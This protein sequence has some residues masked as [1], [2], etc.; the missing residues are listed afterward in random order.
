MTVLALAIGVTAGLL[1]RR[2]VPAMAMTLVAVVGLQIALP[3][4]VQAHLVEPDAMTTKI[5]ADNFA[6]LRGTGGP[7]GGVTIQQFEIEVDEP[8]AWVRSNRTVDSSEEVVDS[9]PSWTE[10][11]APRSAA[12]PAAVDACF[13]RQADAGFR[14]RVEYFPAGRFWAMQGIEAALLVVLAGLVVGVSFWRIRRDLT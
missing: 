5:A 6:G 2:T 7:S 12:G 13:D 8:G 10:G 4:V 3:L 1:V 11:C 9:L 14:Q